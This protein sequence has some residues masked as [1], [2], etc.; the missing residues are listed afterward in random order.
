MKSTQFTKYR[1][2]QRGTISG[3]NNY[4]DY[5]NMTEDDLMLLALD[6]GADNMETEEEY[7]EITCSP[8]DFSNL[9]EKLQENGLSFVEAEVQMVPNNYVTLDENGTRKMEL[10]IEKLEELDDVIEVFHNWEE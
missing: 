6:N 8:S 7:Y 10:I 4:P 2:Q 3:N 5:K 1:K 9:T